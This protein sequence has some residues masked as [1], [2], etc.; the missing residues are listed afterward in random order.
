MD[1]EDYI[2]REESD[3]DFADNYNPFQK[4]NFR[5]SAGNDE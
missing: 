2:S 1:I 3:I 4:V 5:E